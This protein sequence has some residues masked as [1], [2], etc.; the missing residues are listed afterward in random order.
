MKNKVVVI[1]SDH[2]TY[3]KTG[4]PHDQNE[5]GDSEIKVS[6]LMLGCKDEDTPARFIRD[7][8]EFAKRWGG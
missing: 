1:M 4:S 3:Q 7:L 6:F 2:T 5:L 8:R